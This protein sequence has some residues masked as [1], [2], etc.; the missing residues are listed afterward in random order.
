V[1]FYIKKCVL[2]GKGWL[3]HILNRLDLL[4]KNWEVCVFGGCCLIVINILVVSN[5]FFI[6]IL[7]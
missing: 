7:Y 6:K 1:I 2:V 5:I 3:G 4:K